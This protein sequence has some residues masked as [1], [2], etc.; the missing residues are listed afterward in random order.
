MLNMIQLHNNHSQSVCSFGA[1]AV[2]VCYAK[3]QK[4]QALTFLIGLYPLNHL[5]FDHW[6]IE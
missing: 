1:A 5:A 2:N 6:N 4:V 3:N